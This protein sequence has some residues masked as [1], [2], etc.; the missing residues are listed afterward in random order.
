[1]TTI[2]ALIE[3][4][5]SAFMPERLEILDESAAHAGH[6]GHREGGETHFRIRIVAPVFVGKGR[7]DRHRMIN[8][9]LAP[10]FARGLHAL[11]IE[12]YAPGEATRW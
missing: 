10:A 2:K 8:S 4:E 11:A 3:T 12:A 7:V 6:M 1:M 5:L 9:A